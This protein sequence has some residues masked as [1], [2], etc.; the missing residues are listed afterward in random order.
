MSQAARAERLPHVWQSEGEDEVKPEDEGDNADGKL[1][2]EGVTRGRRSSDGRAGGG[3]AS[4]R[5]PSAET[6]Q[7]RHCQR[8]A[9]VRRPLAPLAS[10]RRPAVEA[11][12]VLGRALPLSFLFQHT[13]CDERR[14]LRLVWRRSPS[15]HPSPRRLF[16]RFEIVHRRPPQRVPPGGRAHKTRHGRCATA[17]PGRRDRRRPGLKR[18]STRNSCECGRSSLLSACLSLARSAPSCIS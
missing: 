17:R 18:F 1:E 5:Q 10:P 15:S 12:V 16:S 3:Q 14:A 13:R 6:R 4:I 9:R 7:L 8:W 2:R 11:F